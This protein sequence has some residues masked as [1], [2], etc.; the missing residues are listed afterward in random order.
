MA[1]LGYDAEVGLLWQGLPPTGEAV[2]RWLAV[3]PGVAGRVRALLAEAQEETRR[4][5][6]ER[7][8]AVMA[9]AEALLER[10]TLVG[11]EVRGVLGGRCGYGPE[12]TA[13]LDA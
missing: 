11:E 2:G 1:A 13:V 6:G 5:V 9:V 12:P 7:R 4:I 8:E 10:R 3:R